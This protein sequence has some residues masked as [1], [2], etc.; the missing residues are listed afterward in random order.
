MPYG[1]SPPNRRSPAERA[2]FLICLMRCGIVLLCSIAAVSPSQ[3]QSTSKRPDVLL[4]YTDQ[5]RFDCLGA[6]GHPDIKTPNLDA[7]ARDGVLFRNSFCTWPVCTPSRYS[8]L[9]GQYVHQH[10]GWSNRATLEPTVPTYPRLLQRL[11]YATMAVGKMHFWP[12]YLDVGFERLQ[13]AEQNGRGRFVDDYHRYLK[14]YH[15]VDAIDLIDQ[16]REFRDTAS[17]AYWATFGAQVSDLPEEH[18]STT[19]IGNRAVDAI[20]SWATGP[21][22]LMAGFI[23]PHHPFDP[24]APWHER[25]D[26]DTLTILPGWTDAPPEHDSAYARGYFDNRTLTRPVLRRAMAYYYATISQID[27]HVG[28]M[29][30]ALKAANRYDNALIIFTA[31]HGEFL[32]FHHLLLK[33]NY[34][35]DPLI[36]VPLIVKFPNQKGA[37]TRSDALVSSVDVTTTI[38]RQAGGQPARTMKGRDLSAVA[39]GQAASRRFVF[40]QSRRHFMVRSTTRKLLVD[41]DPSRSMFFDLEKDPQELDNRIGDPAYRDEIRTMTE[42]LTR[43]HLFETP[44][45]AYVNTDER[46]ID[47]PNVP[48]DQS[49]LAREML[50][51]I[52]SRMKTRGTGSR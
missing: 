22:L 37:G 25:Y 7:L 14:G 10:G 26:P 23:K 11:G 21:N 6:M 18:H 29:I 13:L 39:S 2:G 40:A 51:F 38:V 17:D 16:E 4:I 19:W 48:T 8:L 9:T 1:T 32:G 42:A 24:P 43:W 12:P 15:L 35:Y 20:E 27:H 28:R 3:A 50:E 47:K 33:G 34:M 5:F 36:K 44:R 31:D 30:A 41:R 52:R 46:Q 49:G 45:P